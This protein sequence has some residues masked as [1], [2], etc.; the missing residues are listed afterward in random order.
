MLVRLAKL[1]AADRCL[2]LESLLLMI[3]VRAGLAV[4][5]FP[6]LRRAL[7]RL[8]GWIP[9]KGPSR[10]ERIPWSIRMGRRYLGRAASCLV[11]AL[12]AQV[13]Y[14]RAGVAA[15]VRL[16]VRRNDNGSLL[17]H[18]WLEREGVVVLG[19]AGVSLSEFSEL[20]IIESL[21]P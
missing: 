14:A 19:G 15:Q 17:A 18:A 12:S 1:S 5:P 8:A 7:A 20:A 16:G 2:L 13:M 10:V 4:L 21:E 11:Q 9:S 6:T 3:L